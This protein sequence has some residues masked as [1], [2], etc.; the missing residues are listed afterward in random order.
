MRVHE[1][2]EPRPGDLLEETKTFEVPASHGEIRV[3]ENPS[4]SALEA[5]HSRFGQ[6]RGFTLPDGS[7]WVWQAYQATHQDVRKPNAL[8]TDAHFYIADER[9]PHDDA[10]TLGTWAYSN[11]Q[12]TMWIDRK[13]VPPRLRSAFPGNPTFKPMP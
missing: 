4:S 12:M 10:W 13:N 7:Y 2:I 1:I 9:Q 8:D 3:W 6:L 11:P 5:L